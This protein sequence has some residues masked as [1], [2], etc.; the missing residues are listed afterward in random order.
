VRLQTTDNK[1][2]SSVCIVNC[3]AEKVAIGIVSHH[4]SIPQV[5]WKTGIEPES[6][7]GRRHLGSGI[8]FY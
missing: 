2:V 3:I 4:P 5:A 6:D 8:Y 1:Y 7:L